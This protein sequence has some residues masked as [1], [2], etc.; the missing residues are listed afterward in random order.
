MPQE[1]DPTPFE[2]DH[3]IAEKHKGPT[4]AGNLCLS[5]FY[6]NSFK[7]SD[8]S[9]LDA[10]TRKLTP[11]FNP[12]R[13][14]WSRHFRWEG[15]Y[16]VGR[17][18]IGRVTIELLQINDPFRVDFRRGPDGGGAVSAG[19]ICGAAG[20]GVP[21]RDAA[22]RRKRAVYRRKAARSVGRVAERNDSGPWEH[23]VARI[24][25]R[26]RRP[27]SAGAPDW[28]DP[29]HLSA[30]ARRRSRPG[31]ATAG[32]PVPAS[33]RSSQHVSA[34][35]AISVF[36]HPIEEGDGIGDDLVDRVL[37]ADG[38]LSQTGLDSL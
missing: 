8:I 10:V 17:T 24:T 21:W 12:R 27:S 33:A 29:L 11:L 14:K 2:I 23:A 3:I 6:C 22:T 16:L 9:S 13:H 7:G 28:A 31:Y 18:A 26:L 34:S 32:P 1:F 37:N 19:V 4:V 20:G 36:L 25:M 15:P 35:R 38:S 30:T 5:C